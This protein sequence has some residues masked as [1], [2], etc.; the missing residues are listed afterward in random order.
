MSNF[1][2]TFTPKIQAAS[3]MKD[4]LKYTT[5]GIEIL[6]YVGIGV[7][8]GY[9]IDKKTGTEKP[10]FLLVFSLLGCAAAVY[11]II[12]FSGKIK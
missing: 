11:K 2:Y 8:I 3:G 12:R 6:L 5:F 10:W 4:Y 9:Y 7:C 1:F